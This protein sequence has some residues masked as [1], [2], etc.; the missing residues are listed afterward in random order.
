MEKCLSF[1]S[2]F[3]LIANEWVVT[4]KVMKVRIHIAS[5]ACCIAISYPIFSESA[6]VV[7][8]DTCGEITN[9]CLQSRESGFEVIGECSA[10]PSS[11]S[12]VEVAKLSQ[13]NL[14]KLSGSV[15]VSNV[16]LDGKKTEERDKGNDEVEMP[17]HVDFLALLP[18][19]MV[20]LF[21]MLVLLEHR[22]ML[23]RGQTV[24]QTLLIARVHVG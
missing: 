3:G 21:F 4:I 2:S 17:S 24:T 9:S 18:V 13:N 7:P 22:P 19:C 5:A 16:S 12:W 14:P 23:Q 11:E 6:F 8:R 15:S 20:T 1:F 10:I